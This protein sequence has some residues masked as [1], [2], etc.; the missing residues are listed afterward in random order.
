MREYFVGGGSQP[1]LKKLLSIPERLAFA[2]VDGKHQTE[3]VKRE[4]EMI[5]RMQPR[6]AIILFDDVQIPAVAAAV[7]A[8]DG[9]SIDVLA[10]GSQRCY[11]I[12]TKL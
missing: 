4:T 1:L 5:S 2:F 12:A 3:D 11:A 8:I 10:L 6:G 9:Y 7:R